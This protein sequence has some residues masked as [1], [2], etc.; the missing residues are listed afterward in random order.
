MKDHFV[1][2]KFS[3]K[4]FGIELSILLFILG[5]LYFYLIKE[6]DFIFIGILIFLSFS[7]CASLFREKLLFPIYKLFLLIF[8]LIAKVTNPILIMFCY[9]IGIAPLGFGYKIYSIFLKKNNE[10]N[11][12][13]KDANM[14]V[15]NID[16]TEQY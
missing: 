9:M 12:Y 14:S 2:K 1:K 7:L 6:I 11:S 5:S 13:W 3:L 8:G 15:K 16:I 10:Q 4:R